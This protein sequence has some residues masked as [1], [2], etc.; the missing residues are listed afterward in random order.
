MKPGDVLT[1]DE[2]N[3]LPDGARIRRIDGEHAPYPPLERRKGLWWATV[4]AS[5]CGVGISSGAWEYGVGI[6]SGAWEYLGT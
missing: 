1:R 4:L 3:T 5:E 6:G 2:A